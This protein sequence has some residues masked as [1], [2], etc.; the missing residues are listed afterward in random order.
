M[1][2]KNDSLLKLYVSYGLCGFLRLTIVDLLRRT[3]SPQLRL[4]TNKMINN[5]GRFD[6]TQKKAA[7]DQASTKPDGKH[8][9]EVTTHNYCPTQHPESNYHW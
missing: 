4:G 3:Q 5:L 2:I 7:I 8:Y 6:F 9:T 1:W